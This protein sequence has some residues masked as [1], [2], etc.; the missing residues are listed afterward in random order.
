LGAHPRRLL[1]YEFS[2]GL[3]AA[4]SPKSD[5]VFDQAAAI[6][7]ASFRFLRQPSR[8]IAPRPAAKSGRA[9]GSGVVNEE[10]KL[11]LPESEKLYIQN[12]WGQWRRKTTG[13]R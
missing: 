1:M 4:V 8:P 3:L 11:R 6:A 10:S 13:Q 7:A 5:Q 12:T 9:A 2:H